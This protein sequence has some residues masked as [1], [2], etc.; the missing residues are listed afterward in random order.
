MYFYPTQ[1]CSNSVTA[2]VQLCLVTPAVSG[3]A[4]QLVTN[5]LKAQHSHLPGQGGCDQAPDNGQ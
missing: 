4:V 5:L 3:E 2:L 1:I